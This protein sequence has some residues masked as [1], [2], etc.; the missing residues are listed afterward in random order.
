MKEILR[1]CFVL[2]IIAAV[3]AGV[4]AFVNQQTEK[5][6]GKSHLDEKMSAVRS[7]L[8]PFDN[9]P[10][11]DTVKIKEDGAGTTLF[12]RGRKDGAITGVAFAAVAP[13]GYSGEIEIMIGVDTEGIVWGIEVLK[14]L[15]TPGLGSKIETSD[16]RDQFKGKSL[17]DPEQWEVMKDGGVFKQI[18]GAT[19]SSR[20]VT[21]AVAQ[22]LEF[23]RKHS[24]RILEIEEP[25]KEADR[26]PVKEQKE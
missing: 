14:H 20:A 26:V 13:N 19:I 21:F 2:T 24:S 7:V 3:S 18:T 9:E 10:D 11:R 23:F 4:L 16:F 22:S 8:P 15:E 6:I 25:S 17:S 1:L 12:Y 5:P